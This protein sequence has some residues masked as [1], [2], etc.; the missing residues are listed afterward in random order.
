[1][2]SQTCA[3]DALVKGKELYIKSCAVCHGEAG[4]GKGESAPRLTPKPRDFTT[5]AYKI[6]RTPYGEIPTDEDLARAISDGLPGSSMLAWKDAFSRSQIDALVAYIKTFSKRF[7][8]GPPSKVYSL[9]GARKADPASIAN[10]RKIYFEM[11]CNSCHG[12]EGRGDGPAASALRDDSGRPIRAANFHKGWNLRGGNKASDIF[13]TIMTGLNGTPM[14]S[15]ADA[16]GATAEGRAR[17]WDLANYLRS[18]SSVRPEASA[19]LRS[20][21]RDGGLPSIPEDPAWESIPQVGFLLFGQ[22]LEEPREFD[23]SVDYIEARSCF[24]GKELALLLEWDDSSRDPKP[25]TDSLPDGIQVHTP[26][27]LMT[28][29]RS[30]DMPFFLDGGASHALNLWRWDSRSDRVAFLKSTGLSSN[31]TQTPIGVFVTSSSFADGRWQLVLKRPLSVAEDEGLSL[32]PGKFVPIAF[33]VWDGSNGEEGAK[34]SISSWH[35]LLLD[36]SGK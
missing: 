26:V 5:G 3:A 22:I 17:A 35:H 6:R 25:K 31:T 29:S 10:G 13:R 15:Y 34:R 30:E 33:S 20:H 12:K 21:R 24:D 4:D 8:S 27:E 18:L 19:V 23:P 11:Q 32:T 1:M 7:Q 36:S 9:E 14:P 16:F 28:E 2:A